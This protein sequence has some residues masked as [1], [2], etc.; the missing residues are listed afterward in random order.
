[1]K[2]GSIWPSSFVM[3]TVTISWIPGVPS[4]LYVA[5][6]STSC[7][8]HPT[9]LL[10]SSTLKRPPHKSISLYSMNDIG[11]KE[12][13]WSCPLPPLLNTFTCFCMNVIKSFNSGE[14]KLSNGCHPETDASR[15]MNWF[16]EG[17]LSVFITK[18]TSWVNVYKEA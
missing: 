10:F 1:M 16:T 2:S 8:W 12:D 17:Q 3:P 7:R 13:V 18:V 14:K 9:S 4:T 5:V 15:K 6:S 11:H